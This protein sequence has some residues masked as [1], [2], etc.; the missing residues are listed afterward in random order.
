MVV[1]VVGVVVV[2]ACALDFD[3]VHVW[4]SKCGLFHRFA[5]EAIRTVGRHYQN[6]PLAKG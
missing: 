5:F 6:Y 2:L 1:V 4:I 3:V